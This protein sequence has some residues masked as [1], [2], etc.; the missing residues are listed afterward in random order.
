MRVS[1]L[2]RV[3]SILLHA[4]VATMADALGILVE[5]QEAGGLVTNGTAYY[6]AVCE[7]ESAGGSTAIGEGIALPHAS[8]SG[9]A[10]TGVSVLVLNRGIDWGAYDGVPVDLIFMLAVPPRAQSD[11]LQ[12]LARLV[13]L[14][15][16]NGLAGAL[17]NARNAE[18]F[19]QLLAE[20]EGER[21]A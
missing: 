1:D 6:N 9:V 2:I 8:N 4:D 18:E 16:E 10:A 13:N 14:L 21:F 12:M 19:L 7:R 5:L 11:R 20:A 3:E 15:S 17:R